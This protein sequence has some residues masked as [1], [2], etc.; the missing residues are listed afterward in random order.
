MQ[1]TWY[2]LSCFKIAT[3]EAIVLLSPF[4][5]STGLASPRGKADIVLIS[6][7]DQEGKAA[8]EDAG[9][10][11]SGEGEYEV[12]GV[13]INGF[14]F[15]HTVAGKTRK[16]TVYALRADGI[17][18]CHLDNASKEQ[19][20]GLLEKVGEVDVLMI[21]VGG[22]H[23]VGKEE[24]KTLSAEEAVAVVGELEPR[25]VI[26]MYYK[27]PGL[28]LGLA[29][30]ETFLKAMGASGAERAEKLM[31]KKK[32]LPQEETKVVLLSCGSS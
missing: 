10:I 9:F 6:E 26:P 23:R 30:P 1:I 16:S 20:D 3:S 13:L 12:K 22:A 15:F 28:A 5:K 18:V 7:D 25:V 2:G 29:G 27:V 21:P 24:V 4:G 32:D 14:S 17:S 19:V 11:I 8:S 31:L